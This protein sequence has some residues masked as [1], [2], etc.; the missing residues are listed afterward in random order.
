M[1][2]GIEY[3]YGPDEAAFLIKYLWRCSDDRVREFCSLL[4]RGEVTLTLTMDRNLRT[5]V[6]VKHIYKKPGEDEIY[7]AYVDLLKQNGD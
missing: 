5:L 3:Q 2:S 6:L 4:K 1:T 7:D